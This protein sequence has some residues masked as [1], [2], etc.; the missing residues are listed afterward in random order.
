MRADT[1]LEALISLWRVGGGH[2][3]F[4]V[5]RHYAAPAVGWTCLLHGLHV[6]VQ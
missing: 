5:T 4:H 3:H 6:I 1:T 2:L